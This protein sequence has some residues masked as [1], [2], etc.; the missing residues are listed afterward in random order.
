MLDE[1]SKIYEEFCKFIEHQVTNESK[2][3][4]GRQV[5]MARKEL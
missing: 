2:H 1:A 4:I 3:D 5:Q